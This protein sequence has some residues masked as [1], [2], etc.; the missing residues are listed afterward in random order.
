M[1]EVSVT[2]PAAL[3]SPEM[4][5]EILAVLHQLYPTEFQLAKASR[6]LANEA[7][8]RGLLD[9]KEPQTLA[10]DWGKDLTLFGQRRARYLLYR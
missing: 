9:G 10:S 8:M 6:L 5:V 7:T 1:V 3:D 4:G 2:D